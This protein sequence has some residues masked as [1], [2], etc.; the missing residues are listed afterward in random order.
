MQKCLGNQQG[1]NI[2]TV[3]SYSS[4]QQ[5]TQTNSTK[6]WRS[7]TKEIPNVRYFLAFD[8]FIRHNEKTES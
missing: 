6:L 1:K 2:T 5:V 4:R 8:E 7:N 3:T